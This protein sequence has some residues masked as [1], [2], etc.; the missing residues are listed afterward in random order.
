MKETLTYL[1]AGNSLD[2][3]QAYQIMKSIG[4]GNID[5]TQITAFITH[6]W[7]KPVTTQELSGFKRALLALAIPLKIDTSNAIDLCGTGGDGK[8][9]FNIST[10]TAVVVAGAGYKVAKHGNYGVTSI[11]GSSNVLEQLGYTFST[12]SNI[13]AQQLSVCNLTFIH[14]PLFHPALKEVGAIRK[15]LGVKT[16]FNMLGPLVNPA[17]PKY[18]MVGVYDLQVA[19][20]YQY[21]FQQS[22]KQFTIV[23][24]LDGY[25][26]ITL[27]SDTRIIS[28]SFD[29]IK[30]PQDLL[31][32]IPLKAADLHGGETL[33]AAAEIF[34]MVLSGKGSDAQNTAVLTNAALAINT[35][36]SSKK[37][38]DCL[39]EAKESLLSGNAESNFNT[40]ING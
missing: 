24:S 38:Q 11:S 23:H 10:L 7:Y 39:L 32:K 37:L 30:T 15:K 8:N 31:C 26:E 25:D 28:N 22:D 20:Q 35:F 34:K 36:D 17:Q 1:L 3:S 40:L 9:T 19:R 6:Y 29:G 13:L 18:Q 14:A 12:N 5:A 2:E 21:L 16:F 27:T 33:E 4:E